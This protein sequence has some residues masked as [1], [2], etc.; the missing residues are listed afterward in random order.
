MKKHS[1]YKITNNINSRYY[2]GVHSTLNINDS[3]MG[4]GDLIKKSISKYGIDNFKKEILFEYDELYQ[5]YEKERE[6]VKTL[7]EDPLSYN[8][9]SGGKGGWGH[10]NEN[11]NRKQTMHDPDV[12]KKVSNSLKKKYQEDEQYR[13]RLKECAI[14]ACAAAAIRNTGKKRPEHSE[15]LKK[16]MTEGKYNNFFHVRTPSKFEVTA[17]NNEIFIV[18]N[19][20]EFC[21]NN[22]LPYSSLWCTHRSG[23]PCSRGRAKNWKCKLLEK[24]TYEKRN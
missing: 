13:L 20:V 5:A 6:L 23:I 21:Y 2:I 9:N 22:N 7:Y 4:S 3:Y 19:L 14:I 16:M 18:Y 11:P 1:V 17:P 8:M 15:L 12:A 24:G 10:I